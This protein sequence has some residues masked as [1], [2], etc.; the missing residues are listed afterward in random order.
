MTS[1]ADSGKRKGGLFGALGRMFGGGQSGEP[2]EAGADRELAGG[3]P[4]ETAPAAVEIAEPAPLEAADSA[5]EDQEDALMLGPALQ[6]AAPAIGAAPAGEAGTNEAGAA[7]AIA[8]GATAGAGGAEGAE[9]DEEDEILAR[10]RALRESEPPLTGS[11]W[12]EAV[13]ARNASA[14]DGAWTM[15]TPDEGGV[16][17]LHWLS[18]E[19]RRDA[20]V[21]PAAVGA[22]P[23]DQEQMEA[24]DMGRNSDTGSGGDQPAAEDEAAAAE[25]LGLEAGAEGDAGPAREESLPPAEGDDTSSVPDAEKSGSE[26]PDSEETGA[27]KAEDGVV[28]LGPPPDADDAGAGPAMSEETVR[29][30]IRE[31]LEGEL[32]ERLS[33]NIR[34][35]IR[36]EVAHAL[37]RQ[38]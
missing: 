30:L 27:E 5:G 11:A 28:A 26:G 8:G 22:G 16:A 9:A 24:E 23:E 6:S 19:A 37:L 31:E 36:E 10:L 18:G 35:M 4:T 17:G 21:E 1:E 20:E 7:P 38:R 3:E 34:R 2:A 12:D 33:A 13:P 25:P 14:D 32:G 29:R 15:D